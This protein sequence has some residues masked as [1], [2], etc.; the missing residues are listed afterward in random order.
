MKN[1]K[2]I[3]NLENGVIADR[4]LTIDSILLSQ[5][6]KIKR[7]QGKH[8][9]FKDD[10]EDISFLEKREGVLSGSIWYLE[11]NSMVNNHFISFYKKPEIRK[12]FDV[13][14]ER[15]KNDAEYK[16]FAMNE[17]V[18]LVDSLHFYVTGDQNIIEKLLSAIRF[19]GKKNSI[20]YGKVSSI[21]VLEID[22]NKGFMLN[23]T[24][25]SKPLPCDRFNVQSHKI[26]FYRD[27]PPYWSNKDIVACYMPTLFLKESDDRSMDT[28]GFKSSVLPYLSNTDFA[29]QATKGNPSIDTLVLDEVK[30]DARK[31]RW[32]ST[33]EGGICG[34][35]GAYSKEGI[36]GSANQYAKRAIGD[37]F[38]DYNYI[39]SDDFLSLSFLWSLKVKNLKYLANTL[40]TKK[41]V[42]HLYGAKA[43]EGKKLKDYLNK[44]TKLNPP[45]SINIKDTMNSQHVVFKNR[46]SLSNA[47]ILM[48]YGNKTL[49]IDTEVL[50]SAKKE[51]DK[52]LKT[53]DFI[54]KSHL[55]G[56]FSDGYH[57]K[58]NKANQDEGNEII[59]KY[60]GK[61]DKTIRLAGWLSF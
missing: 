4:L 25:P 34:V 19:I 39:Q 6:Y 56:N 11:D 32:E 45:F 10:T 37:A 38:S 61:Y 1:L 24:T 57:P 43:E 28:K 50:I 44:P 27:R 9:A 42:S 30:K 47:F 17:E 49:F 29:M 40:I 20:G 26:A 58:V 60:Q 7:V 48:Q 54:K 41:G 52:I 36:K 15:K 18:M 46:V 21:Q 23:K 12:I 8:T 53:H 55:L 3:I 13:T 33:E 5:Y 59:A 14:Q 2:V 16:S 31:K 22:E 51:Y 35:T